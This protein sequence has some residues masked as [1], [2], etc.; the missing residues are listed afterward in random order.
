M[1]PRPKEQPVQSTPLYS[2]Q[3]SQGSPEIKM[4]WNPCEWILL[5]L[6]N[7]HFLPYLFSCV[8]SIGWYRIIWSTM[9]DVSDISCQEVTWC[10]SKQVMACGLLLGEGRGW[11]PVGGDLCHQDQGGEGGHQAVAAHSKYWSEIDFLQ[12]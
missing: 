3:P 4:E 5:C 2:S 11:Q 12:N 9:I 8:Y 1:S 10:I 7:F 6:A